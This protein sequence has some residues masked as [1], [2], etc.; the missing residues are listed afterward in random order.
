[1]H[2]VILAAGYGRRMRPLSDDCHKGLLPIGGTTALDRIVEEVC[3]LDPAVIT[4][5]TGYRAEDVEAHLR[6]GHP[7][8]PLHFLR[9]ERFAETNNVVSLALALDQVEPGIELLLVECDVLLAPGVLGR[10]CAGPER[11]V[12][13]VDRFGIGM[14]GT[15]VT[16]EGGRITGMHPTEEQGEGFEY[17]GTFKTLNV[18]RFTG[19][20]V[21]GTL[22]PLLKRHA[23]RIDANAFYEAV[24]AQVPDLAGLGIEAEE[25]GPAAWAEIDDP[26]DLAAARFRFAPEERASILDRTIGGQWG[27]DVLDFSFMANAYFPTPSMLAAMRHGLDDLVGG[28]GS[29]QTVLNEKLAWL[30]GCEPARVEVLH[31]ASQAFPILRRLWDGRGVAIPEPTFGEY[32]RVFDAAATYADAPGV[33]MNELERL[34]GEE[35]VL[36]VVNP[37]SPTGTTLPTAALHALAAAHPDTTLLVDESFLAFSE[38]PSLEE[39]L[40]EQ[41]LPNVVV[42]T[43]LSKSLGVPGMRLGYVYSSDREL[44]DAIVAELPIWNLGSQAEHLLELTL[45]SR[46]E[47]AASF[48]RTALDREELR[49]DLLAVP[50]VAAVYPSGGN[51]LLTELTGA[52]GIAAA[53]RQGLL[54]EA[55]IE[56]KDV[57]ERFSDR[58][59]RLRVAVRRPEENAR[60]I[61][62]LSQRLSPATGSRA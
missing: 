51:F 3:A 43:S 36:A 4:V 1:M 7:D 5:V 12:A 55:A 62:A 26:V 31:G 56:V 52:P 33:D 50:G 28:Y 34:A 35:D 6:A 18:Y 44:L 24:L 13:L 60:L 39:A 42:L 19:E 59:P 37:N 22:R 11:N 47:L 14:D 41:P 16:V 25:V 20:L 9:N 27:F 23:E 32:R 40:E 8:S 58:V 49:R 15:V 54:A 17:R 48:E 61:Q 30:L 53:L 46:P 57:T 29:T 21:A 10:L 38:Q 45:K 2:A